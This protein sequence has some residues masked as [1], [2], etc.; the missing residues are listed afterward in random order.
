MIGTTVSHYRI[1]EKLGAGGMGVV[2]KAEDT[3]LGRSVALKFLPDD[4][5][6]DQAPRTV[7]NFWWGRLPAW[8]RTRYCGPCL[9]LRGPRDAWEMCWHT[10]RRRSNYRSP[11]LYPTQIVPSGTALLPN[12]WVK[13]GT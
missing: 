5:A 8:S 10:G 6:K 4:Y 11:K 2:Y 12:C 13:L 7:Q 1:L 9:F 3:R